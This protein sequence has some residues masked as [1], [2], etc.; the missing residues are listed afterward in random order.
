M[1]KKHDPDFMELLAKHGSLDEATGNIRFDGMYASVHIDISHKG[2]VV[3][4][5]HS[6]AVWFLKYRQWPKD[7]Y[8]IDHVDNDPM[9][10]APDNLAEITHEKNQHKRRGRTVSRI[11]GTGKY[12]YGINLHSDKRD[13]R[14]YVT[15]CLSRGHGDGDLKNIRKSL[16]GYDSKDEAESAIQ[17][18]IVEIKREGE[19]FLPDVKKTEKRQTVK[20]RQMTPHIRALRIKG[21]TLSAIS[22]ST[23][24]S[25]ITIY[26]LTKDIEWHEVRGKD[27]SQAKLTDEKVREARQLRTEGMTWRPLAARYGVAVNAIV[28]AV[29][30]KTWSHVV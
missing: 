14:F 23:G 12:G 20:I 3:S 2:S 18:F 1:G 6:H 5:P 4:V 28:N 19:M 22:E 29:K 10:N 30:G 27:R 24:F 8:Q 9:N 7:G 15:R 16:G 25:K 21:L 26:N 13:G 17:M 11:Y